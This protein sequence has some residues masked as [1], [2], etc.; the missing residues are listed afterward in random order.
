MSAAAR[1]PAAFWAVKG[2]LTVVNIY[3]AERLWKKGRRGQAIAMMLVSNGLMV[4]VA[5]R[6]ASVLRAQ[7]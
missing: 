4:A 7:R 3:V 2:G 6:N 1:N 5:A